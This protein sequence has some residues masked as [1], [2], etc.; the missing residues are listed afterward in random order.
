MPLGRA[1]G[2]RPHPGLR[3][4]TAALE[5][6][7]QG[8][9]GRPALAGL[10]GMVAM[11]A[12]DEPSGPSSEAGA[13]PGRLPYRRPHTPNDV[14]PVPDTDTP[15]PN[16]HHPVP[17]EPAE[18]TTV[19]PEAAPPEPA[20]PQVPDRDAESA[21]SW[22]W[23]HAAQNGDTQAFGRLY[24]RYVDTV[25]RFIYFR[26]GD[27]TQA[28]DL[29]SETFVRALRRLQSLSNQGRDPVAW[30]VTIAR[31][32]LLDHVKSA[33]Y[34]LEV[35]N[36]DLLQPRSNEATD[37]PSAESVVLGSLTNAR[38]LEAVRALSAEQRECIVL[39]FLHGLSVAETAEVMGKN[40]GAIKAMQ[41]RAIRRLH[42]QLKDELR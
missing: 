36:D 12:L 33:R 38:L 26:L 18:D 21:E 1:F 23:V 17:A 11:T 31:N 3:R 24:E 14:T 4:I 16:G 6:L 8:A 19:L 15:S 29:T 28:E 37:S 41:H 32:L 39:R 10:P 7:A 9:L 13:T 30:F 27:R 25:F 20:E 22:S 42:G 34:R 2:S 5:H 40:D 35:T